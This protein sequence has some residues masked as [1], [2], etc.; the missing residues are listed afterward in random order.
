MDSLPEFV[1]RKVLFQK[2]HPLVAWRM[3]LGLSQADLAKMARVSLEH[4]KSLEKSNSHLRPDHLK[5]FS[6]ALGIPP[7]FLEIRYTHQYP[8]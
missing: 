1:A 6:K 3:F 2:E 7:G 4:L 5:I 8:N